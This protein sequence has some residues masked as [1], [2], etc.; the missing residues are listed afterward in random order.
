VL[1]PLTAAVVAAG[2]IPRRTPVGL[3]LEETAADG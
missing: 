1:R 3:D 2:E